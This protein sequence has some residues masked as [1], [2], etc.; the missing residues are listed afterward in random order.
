[1]SH[2]S[3]A[4]SDSHL[5][6]S[7]P[8]GITFCVLFLYSWTKILSN[9]KMI[10]ASPKKSLQTQDLVVTVMSQC[11]ELIKVQAFHSCGAK[12]EPSTNMSC[13]YNIKFPLPNANIHHIYFM[14][15]V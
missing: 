12:M 10:F 1:M 8:R 3:S 11:H 15:Y 6:T 2:V 13:F 9:I 14:Q 7:L 5:T 4:L